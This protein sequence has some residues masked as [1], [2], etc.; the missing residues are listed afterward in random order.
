MNSNICSICKQKNLPIDFSKIKSI[1]IKNFINNNRINKEDYSIMIKKCNC[2][3]KVHKFCILLNIIFN[4]E[5]KCPDCN[6]FYNITV[7]KNKDNSEKCKIISII[8]FL[9]IIHIILYGCCAGLVIFN[10]NKF[11]MNDFTTIKKDKYMHIQYFFALILL[12]LNTYLI[13]RS[14]KSL[15]LRF[16]FCYKYFININ[17]KSSNNNID[18]SKYFRPLYGFYRSFYN[19]RLRYLVCKRNENFFSN[20]INYNKDFQN[21][22]INNNKEFQH[23]SNGRKDFYNNNINNNKNKDILKLKNSE[24]NSLLEKSNE[25]D[26][27]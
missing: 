9:T 1:K 8:I 27:M 25:D 23:I 19:Q 2:N 14:I 17:E 7:T 10:I 11:K 5:L 15:I 12:I 16:K 24:N 13:S 26:K 18:D 22:I 4:Y 3:K 20:R 21:L 6:C